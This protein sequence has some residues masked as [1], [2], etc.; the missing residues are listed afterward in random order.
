MGKTPSKC[1]RCLGQ[2]SDAV[3]AYFAAAE[4]LPLRVSG[5]G[6]CQCHP[7]E[8]LWGM[9]IVCP[10]SCFLDVCTTC[11]MGRSWPLAARLYVSLCVY[12][13]LKD[14][15]SFVPGLC[16]PFV[17]LCG[18]VGVGSDKVQLS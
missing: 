10:N 2:G 14:I 5:P 7:V 4:G 9:F 1:G 11:V 16:Q 13:T 12:V 17:R 6:L 15:I 3:G 18:A 8:F